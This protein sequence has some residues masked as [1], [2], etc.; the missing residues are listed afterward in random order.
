MTEAEFEAAVE[1]IRQGDKDGLKD[2]YLAYI[3]FIYS[4]VF[5]IVGSKENAEDVTSDVFI[6]LWDALDN[7]KPGHGHKGFLATIAR[8]AAID[9]MRKNGREIPM[10]TE[11]SDEEES[12]SGAG[13][14]NTIF[15]TGGTYD[16]VNIPQTEE[17]VIGD[18]TVQEALDSLSPPERDVVSRKVLGDMSF[19]EIAEELGAPMGTITWRYQN[20]INKLRRL[21]YE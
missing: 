14:S 4:V 17:K 12:S 2:I 10:A 13:A 11:A 18:F 9:F 6:K 3:K 7:Y 20:A 16:P 8:N 21:G 19:K 5:N 15:D 1:K